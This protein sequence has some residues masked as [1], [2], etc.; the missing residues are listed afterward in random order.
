VSLKKYRTIGLPKVRVW[1][2]FCVLECRLD[3]A[4]ATAW[5]LC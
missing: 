5:P 2:F 1:N 4:N 3:D